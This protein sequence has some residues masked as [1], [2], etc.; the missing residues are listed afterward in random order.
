MH[1]KGE[2]EGCIFRQRGKKTLI[3]LSKYNALNDLR[4]AVMN[5]R[6]TAATDAQALSQ[7]LPALVFEWAFQLAFSHCSYH[8][9]PGYACEAP[10]LQSHLPKHNAASVFRQ[11]GQNFTD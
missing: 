6:G 11:C 5:V 7:V 3:R 1:H 10:R 8:A 4:L 2:S 9:S